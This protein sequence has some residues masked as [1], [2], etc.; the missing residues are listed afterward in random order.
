MRRSSRPGFRLLILLAAFSASLLP[1]DGLARAQGAQAATICQIQGA[2][3]KTAMDGRLVRVEGVVT[4]AFGG[5]DIDGFFIQAPGCDADAATSD[6]LWIF[7]GSQDVTVRKGQR[8]AVTGRV[9][10][11]YTLT[12]VQLGKDGLELLGEDGPVVAPV[13]VDALP[14]DPAQAA[15]YLEPFEGMLVGLP[16]MRVV[17]ATNGYGETYTV[18]ADSDVERLFRATGDGRRMGVVANGNWLRADHGDRLEGVVGNLNLTFDN[19][20]VAVGDPT[21]VKVWPN[22]SL[23]PGRF[24]PAK[25]GELTVG[26]Y[27]L[28]NFFD[29]LDEDGKNDTE[30]T[31]TPERYACELAGRAHSIAEGLGAPHV[32]G[33]AE[34]ETKRVLQD[35]VAQPALAPFHYRPELI[36]GLDE[37]GIDVG[38]IYREDKLRLLSLEQAQGC[39][40]DPKIDEPGIRCTTAGGEQGWTL[41]ARPP[42]LARFQVLGTRERF[43]LIANHFKSKRGGEDA[44]VATR[45]AQAAHLLTLVERQE[46]LEPGVPVIVSGDLNDFEDSDPIKTLTGSGKLKD[47]HADRSLGEARDQYSF[48]FNGISQL[49]DFILVPPRMELMAFQ[50]VH[51]NLDFGTEPNG[52]FCYDAARH[53]RVSDHDP[54]AARISLAE[55]P[56]GRERIFLPLLGRGMAREDL[57]PGVAPATATATAPRP[58]AMAS[59]TGS[60][61]TPQPTVT[62]AT[63]VPTVPGVPGTGIDIVDIVFNG[64]INPEE[65]DEYVLLRNVSDKAQDLSGWKL[66]SLNPSGLNN[67][68]FSFPA[69]ALMAADQSCRVYTNEV[70][71]EHCGFNWGSLQAIWRNAG[72]KA[73]LRD[74]TG[75]L[76]DAFCYGDRVTECP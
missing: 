33:L 59:A 30:W 73:E 67:P 65:P 13:M 12:E 34:I 42:L 55:L 76:V 75:A 16:I 4:G 74:G 57:E 52:K 37:R 60:G 28:E 47:P 29:L 32:V 5:T 54:L 36:E 9:A 25:D 43:T 23:R 45:R 18:P 19:W 15:I 62:G 38:L 24:A 10:E 70:H 17:G 20:K 6:G 7:D 11:H 53:M 21:A 1:G 56:K 71:P 26:S 66:I 2:G 44:T 48:I 68:E 50:H 22:G 27:N 41:F 69:G 40:L 46:R 3:D 39:I 64:D 51:V 58:T 61:A 63:P 8:V 72:D 35:L 31:P 49:L 14:P